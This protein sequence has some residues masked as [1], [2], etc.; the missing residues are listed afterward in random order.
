MK[1]KKALKKLAKVESLLSSIIDQYDT[2][3]ERSLREALASAKESVIRA[4][5]TVGHHQ[6]E[7]K[8]V[9]KPSAK[10]AASQ[11][12]TGSRGRRSVRVAAA[13]Q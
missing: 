4:K 8:A 6:G 5:E 12:A 11:G 1:T 10:A 13:G 9:R 3:G 7:S 2:N